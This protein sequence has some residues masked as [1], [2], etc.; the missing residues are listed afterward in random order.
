VHAH[1]MVK[2]FFPFRT[3]KGPKSSKKGRFPPIML[4]GSKRNFRQSRR[5]YCTAAALGRNFRRAGSLIR[6]G[7]IR[8]PLFRFRMLP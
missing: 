6:F 5:V 7:K 2:M 4:R 1:P 8:R 3:R